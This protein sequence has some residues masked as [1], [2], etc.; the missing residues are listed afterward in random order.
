MRGSPIGLKQEGATNERF[1]VCL[2]AC[3]CQCLHVCMRRGG[4]KLCGRARVL[5]C[6]LRAH[7]RRVPVSGAAVLRAYRHL[8]LCDIGALE[9]RTHELV[10]MLHD[11]G[12]DDR[13]SS[14]FSL[15]GGAVG[16]ERKSSVSSPSE[17]G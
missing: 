7:L 10:G 11:S 6:V 3:A 1:Y 16:D 15:L 17:G 5:A 9:N 12:G 4:G 13:K 2:H 8:R 14:V